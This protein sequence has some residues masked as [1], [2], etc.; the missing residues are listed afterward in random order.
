MVRCRTLNLKVIVIAYFHYNTMRSEIEKFQDEA[1]T[2]K[3]LLER[4][5]FLLDS[6]ESMDEDSITLKQLIDKLRD[7][8]LVI[9]LLTI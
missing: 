9:E 8:E 6:E 4:W 2:I 5:K 3:W 7:V 1:S